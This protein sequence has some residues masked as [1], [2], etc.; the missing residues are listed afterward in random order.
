MYAGKY[1]AAASHLAKSIPRAY[2]P[3]RARFFVAVCELSFV[4]E[5][6]SM[7]MMRRAWARLSDDQR[8]KLLDQLEQLLETNP[9]L[10]EQVH[11]FIDRAFKPRNWK[12]AHELARELRVRKAERKSRG[13]ARSPVYDE[14]LSKMSRQEIRELAERVG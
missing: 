12:P 3:R 1:R 6:H 4:P 8:R 2:D 13:A 7:R 10:I 11:D 9:A 5:A 14:L